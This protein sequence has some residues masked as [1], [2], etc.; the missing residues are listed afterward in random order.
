MRSSCFVPRI[1]GEMVDVLGIIRTELL[2]EIIQDFRWTDFFDIFRMER[3]I[4]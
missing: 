1:D 3:H 4:Y 2:R